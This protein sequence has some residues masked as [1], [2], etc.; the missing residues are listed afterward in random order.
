M[1]TESTEQVAPRRPRWYG[2]TPAKFLLALLCIQGVLFLS[3]Q[4]R[5]F[6]FNERKGYT[7]LIT[8]AATA[9][10][11]LFLVGLVL[12]SRLFKSKVQFSLVTLLLVVV[13][14]GL[15]CA[16]LAREIES[17]RQQ[18]ALLE[19][20]SSTI[21]PVYGDQSGYSA[22]RYA[23][24]PKAHDWVISVMGQDFVDDVCEVACSSTDHSELEVLK[25]LPQLRCVWLA[26]KPVTGAQLQHLQRLKHLQL[27]DLDQTHFDDVGMAHLTGLV[28]LQQ[29][30]LNR[31]QVTDEGLACLEG[32][33][34]LIVLY[35]ESTRV[36]DKGLE[37][38]A[39][40]T[41][42]W[43]LLLSDT[44]V[45]D[46][47]LEHLKGMETLRILSL[48][49]TSVTDNG[50]ERLAGLTQLQQLFL[51]N[52]GISDAG[53]QH[54]R[55]LLKLGSLSLDNTDVTDSGLEE[56]A[57]LT[58]LHSLGLAKT[59]VTD[60]GLDYMKGLS[61]LRWLALDYTDVT[62]E[63]VRKLRKALPG[64]QITHSP[65]TAGRE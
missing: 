12:A 60:A 14:M 62:D 2:P 6:A 52:T 48:G 65:R 50:L 4:Y 31:T 30:R 19:T 63:G 36:T 59:R 1:A 5:W 39:H 47:G 54:L 28:E 38:L 10:G 34:Q 46:Q 35:L 33:T 27:L 8:V 9:I 24:H 58:Q 64:C 11:L 49:G 13:V 32:N 7:V 15:P 20:H 29:L 57:G 55:G 21:T 41:Q 61:G 45:S 17:A 26:G 22:K 40:H 51:H 16:W 18:R 56:L 3:G 25:A 42:L 43:R 53:L 37:H 23:V 44:Q